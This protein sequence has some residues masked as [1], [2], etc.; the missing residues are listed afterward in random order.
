MLNNTLG[1]G[2]FPSLLL[3]NPKATIFR[4]W[5]PPFS[6]FD[7]CCCIN[8]QYRELRYCKRFD[9]NIDTFSRL[10]TPPLFKEKFEISNFGLNKPPFIRKIFM[11]LTIDYRNSSTLTI[12]IEKIFY[13]WLYIET[14]MG[15]LEGGTPQKKMG[16][17]GV[18]PPPFLRSRQTFQRSVFH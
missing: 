4:V 2:T 14:I 13:C 6:D 15:G 18:T 7:V 3:L 11:L 17:W 9:E 10:I 5:V 8:I 1:S 16:V 12:D